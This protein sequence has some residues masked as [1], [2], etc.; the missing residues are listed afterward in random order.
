MEES[1]PN[2]SRTAPLSDRLTFESA[3]TTRKINKL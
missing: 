3:E 1:S 2:I